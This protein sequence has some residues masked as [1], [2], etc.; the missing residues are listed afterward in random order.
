LYVSFEVDIV[1]FVF[2]GLKDVFS[3]K[4]FSRQIDIVRLFANPSLIPQNLTHY[5]SRVIS[6]FPQSK[7][8]FGIPRM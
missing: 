5:I 3:L 4:K 2:K 8:H 7:S 1:F 6:K